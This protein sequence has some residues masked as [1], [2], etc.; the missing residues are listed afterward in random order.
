MAIHTPTVSAC[1]R[2]NLRCFTMYEWIHWNH[3]PD[4]ITKGQFFQICHISKATARYLLQSGKVPCQNTDKRTRCYQIQKEDV[5]EYLHLHKRG[6]YPEHY[7]A[8]SS[9]YGARLCKSTGMPRNLSPKPS[10]GSTATIQR[11]L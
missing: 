6:I 5:Q 11:C 10:T 9:W 2:K 8:S 1:N 3:I 4:I 7:S